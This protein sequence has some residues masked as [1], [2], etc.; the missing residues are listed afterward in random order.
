MSTGARMLVIGLDGATWDVADPLIEAGRLPNL[1]RIKREGSIAQLNSTNPPMTLPSWSSMLTGCNP[2]QHGIFDFVQRPSASWD[3]EFV[4]ATHRK[5]PT[6]HRLISDRGGRVASIAVPTTWPPEELNGV[7]VSGFDSPVSTGIDGTFCHPPAL[8][9]ELEA[10]FGGLKFADF[11]ESS[12]GAGWHRDAKA[13][14]LSEVQ[15]KEQIGSWLMSQERWDCFMLLFGESDTVSHHFWMHYDQDSPRHPKNTPKE[16]REAIPDVYERLD[17]AL[18][19]LI[20]AANPDWIC[21]CSDHGFGGAGLHVLY[22]N[23]FLEQQGWLRYRRRAQL[24]RQLDRIKLEAAGR[25]PS[26]LQGRMFRALPR[27]FRDKLESQSRFGGVDFL[28]TRAISDEMNYSAT[29]R[30]NLPEGEFPVLREQLLA[31][32]VDGHHPIEKVYR[33]EEIYTGEAVHLS[34]EI[35]LGLGLRDGYSYTLLPSHRAQGDWRVLE[36][37]EYVGGKGLG[38]NGSHRQFGL[39]GLWGSGV[40]SG[41]VISAGMEDIAP[42]LLHLMGEPIPGHM[43]GRLLS[44]ALQSGGEATYGRFDG[45]LQGVKEASEKESAAIRDRLERLGYL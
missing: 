10:R 1:A 32:E 7:V 8:Y 22:L 23:R 5:V 29:L 6:L 11:Q 27:R 42:T 15:R 33:R 16:L 45:Q 40:A 37:C 28:R 35:I 20:A 18:G 2:G 44:E 9:G 25:I 34:P 4:N 38:M 17:Q 31:W 19:E 24:V 43:D 39:L 41:K 30:L 3:L 12:I 21:L 36:P 26:H 13:A 14:L